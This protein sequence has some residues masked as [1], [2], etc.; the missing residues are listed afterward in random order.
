MPII[1][2]KRSHH[3]LRHDAATLKAMNQMAVKTATIHDD[4]DKISGQVSLIGHNEAVIVF[5]E[6]TAL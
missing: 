5:N 4:S 6:R 3:G 2:S 1:G